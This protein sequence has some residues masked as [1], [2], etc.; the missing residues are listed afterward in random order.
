M[1]FH[2]GTQRCFRGFRTFRPLAQG[3]YADRVGNV[4][5]DEIPVIVVVAQVFDGSNEVF[6]LSG[7]RLAYGN[8][9]NSAAQTHILEAVFILI[10]ADALRIARNGRSGGAGV[11]HGIVVHSSGELHTIFLK[12]RSCEQLRQ[13]GAVHRH[14][15]AGRDLHHSLAADF[16]IVGGA[17]FQRFGRH[18]FAECNFNAGCSA[19]HIL[20]IFDA[21]HTHLADKRICKGVILIEHLVCHGRDLFPRKCRLELFKVIVGRH[22]S[23]AL[24]REQQDVQLFRRHG[25][26]IER[27]KN[28]N[29]FHPIQSFP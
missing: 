29:I 9:H 1:I 14:F 22:V 19:A 11:G 23:R 15:L 17:G 13:P 12:G 10:Q 25:F 8:Q 27:G 24:G 2:T 3:S 4:G 21:S 28:L 5:Q 16:G 26:C 20:R 7:I 6:G 18:I